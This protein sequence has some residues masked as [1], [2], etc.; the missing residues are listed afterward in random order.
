[1]HS[2]NKINRRDTSCKSGEIGLVSTVVT[3]TLQAEIINSQT[4]LSKRTF[5]P[6]AGIEQH[7]QQI[8][9]GTVATSLQKVIFIASNKYIFLP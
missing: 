3:K 5:I 4:Q 6:C 9:L 8:T 1:M 2:R 7:D